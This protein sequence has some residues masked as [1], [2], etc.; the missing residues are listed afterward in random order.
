MLR[1]TGDKHTAL[2]LYQ[3]FKW[4]FIATLPS[5]SCELEIAKIEGWLAERAASS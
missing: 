4:E 2:Q 5:Q 3:G 1:A